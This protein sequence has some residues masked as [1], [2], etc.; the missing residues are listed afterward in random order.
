MSHVE[1]ANSRAAATM[2]A[3]IRK[4]RVKVVEEFKV[5][6]KACLKAALTG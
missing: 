6:V 4:Q 2:R 1:E 5:K 3:Q